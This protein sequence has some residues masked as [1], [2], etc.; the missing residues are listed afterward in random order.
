[1]TVSPWLSFAVWIGALTGVAISIV[2]GIVFII[3]FYVAGQKVRLSNYC[4]PKMLLL[5]CGLRASPS[6]NHDIV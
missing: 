6:E 2:I 3:L 4:T 1:M 5:A